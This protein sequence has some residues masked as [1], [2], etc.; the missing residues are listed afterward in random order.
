MSGILKST[1]WTLASNVWLSLSNIIFLKFLSDF[2]VSDIFG[3]NLYIYSNAI[4]IGSVF[5][6]GVGTVI[7]QSQSIKEKNRNYVFNCLNS[8]LGLLF[9]ILLTLFLVWFLVLDF[10]LGGLNFISVFYGLLIVFFY[11]FDNINRS[12]LIGNKIIVPV[13]I[14]L[15]ISSILGWSVS[16]ICSYLNVPSGFL[17]G[18][19]FSAVANFLFSL[20]LVSL[21]IK[22]KFIFNFHFFW[23]LLKQKVGLSLASQVLGSLPQILISSA[24]LVYYGG[25]VVAIYLIG[26]YIF[27]GR[28]LFRLQSNVFFYL[29]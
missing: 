1:S 23:T 19:L 17:I 29:I 6:I 13:S 22:L 2:F 26:M 21:N 27:R 24:L 12:F 20:Y 14:F 16:F 10:P 15:I 4:L 18:M 7:N 25:Q 11:C 9:L 8:Y 5:G 3:E 28:Y